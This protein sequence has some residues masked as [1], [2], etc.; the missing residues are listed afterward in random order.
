MLW[1][2]T[3]WFL[4]ARFKGNV[5]AMLHR[6]C[7]QTE[8]G[9]LKGALMTQGCWYPSFLFSFFLYQ[10]GTCHWLFLGPDILNSWEATIFGPREM[11]APKAGGSQPKYSMFYCLQLSHRK[12]EV[13]F[14]YR[15]CCG[16]DLIPALRRM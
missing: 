5:L 1:I 13:V 8:Q 14:I 4:V 9:P 2:L 6:S 12:E 3:L 10:W 15:P 7:V 16:H 11:F